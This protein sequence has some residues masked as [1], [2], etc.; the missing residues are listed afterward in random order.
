[1]QGITVIPSP[2]WSPRTS[3]DWC[4]DGM[5]TDSM[6]MLPAVRC[7]KH[8]DVFDDFIYCVKCVEE[9]L[10]PSHILL[11]CPEKSY[12]RIKSFLNSACS[13]VRYNV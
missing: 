6:L 8:P 12:E 3:L 13:F 4:L 2:T 7:I 11:R 5:P 9:T 10:Q 1:M